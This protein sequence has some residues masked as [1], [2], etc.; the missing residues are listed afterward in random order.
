MH[1]R[2]C[3]IDLIKTKSFINF[4]FRH[5]V[6]FTIASLCKRKDSFDLILRRSMIKTLK[7]YILLS[8]VVLGVMQIGFTTSVCWVSLNPIFLGTIRTNVAFEKLQLMN[9]KYAISLSST[10]ITND[11]RSC[12]SHALFAPECLIDVPPLLI[13]FSNFFPSRIF[14]SQVQVFYGN[15]TGRCVRLARYISSKWCSNRSHHTVLKDR[16]DS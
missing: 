14:L 6:L 16:T 2:W 15:L 13:S 5:G 1:T 9:V 11:E 7:I 3:L 12:S 8:T 4:W 10:K